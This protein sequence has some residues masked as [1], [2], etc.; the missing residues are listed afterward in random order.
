MGWTEKDLALRGQPDRKPRSPVDPAGTIVRGPNKTEIAYSDYLHT[1]SWL[2]ISPAD[3]I[4][5]YAFEPLKVRIGVRCWWTPDFLVQYAD[6]R[7]ELHDVKGTKNG[8]YR[9][10]DDAI[11]KARSVS[12]NF[13]LPVFFVWRLKNGEWQKQRM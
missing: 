12:T 10:E 2:P 9:A 7:M 3:R 1:Q 4:H 6:G 5:W 11:V 13:P 8:K